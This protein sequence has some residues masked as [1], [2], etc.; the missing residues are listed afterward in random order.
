MA[1]FMYSMEKNEL[2]CSVCKVGQSDD[3]FSFYGIFSYDHSHGFSFSDNEKLPDIFRN[4][5][6]HV[7]SHLKISKTHI[8]NLNLDLEK[9]KEKRR[10]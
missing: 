10:K 7:K 2:S 8:N 5:K 1:G 3:N 9:Q 4:L 6:K